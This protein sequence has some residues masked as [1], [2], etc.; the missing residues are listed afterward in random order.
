LQEGKTMASALDV[1]KWFLSTI[2][3]ESGDSITN[4][5][6]QKLIYYAQAWSLVM[7]KRPLFSEPIEAWAHGPAVDVVFQEYK[8]FSFNAIPLPDS[9]PAFTPEEIR[10]LQDIYEVYGEK[11]AK[12]LENLTHD[13]E[14]WRTARGNLPPEA[15]SRKEISHESMF[16]Y[17]SKWLDGNGQK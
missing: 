13:E 14:P 8:A 3:R 7:L 1:A 12:A 9:I 11:T 17:Y 2:D 6:L 10:L 15:R 4:L 5:K 16:D